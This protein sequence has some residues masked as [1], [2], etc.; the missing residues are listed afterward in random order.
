MSIFK[1]IHYVFFFLEALLVML[2]ITIIWF[3][4]LVMTFMLMKG[5]PE[6]GGAYLFWGIIFISGIGQISFWHATIRLLFKESLENVHVFY[7]IGLSGVILSCVLIAWFQGIDIDEWKILL[8]FS[9]LPV[10]SV[11]H[12]IILLRKNINLQTAL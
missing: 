3:F 11:I 8:Y 2:P 9:V 10:I 6:G 4:G 5:L 7:K 12:L 1:I